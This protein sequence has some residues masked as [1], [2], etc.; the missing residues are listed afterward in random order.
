MDYSGLTA[1]IEQEIDDGKFAKVGSSFD[2]KMS[3]EDMKEEEYDA[4]PDREP[5]SDEVEP[6][7]QKLG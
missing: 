3:N 5:E 7:P 6:E 2:S 4:Q 1:G